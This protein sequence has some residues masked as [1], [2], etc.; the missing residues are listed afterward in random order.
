MLVTRNNTT[1]ENGSCMVAPGDPFFLNTIFEAT[2]NYIHNKSK[3]Q[4][5]GERNSICDE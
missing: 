4:L 1:D 2:F 5:C 3:T